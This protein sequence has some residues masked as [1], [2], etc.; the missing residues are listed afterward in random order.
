MLA[1]AC[2]ISL[3]MRYFKNSQNFENHMFGLISQYRDLM[4]QS[5]STSCKYLKPGS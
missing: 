2:K 4:V 3:N 5:I 1:E